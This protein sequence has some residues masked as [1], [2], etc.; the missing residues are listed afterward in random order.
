[1]PPI[2]ATIKSEN[3]S[4]DSTVSLAYQQQHSNNSSSSS[5]YNNNNINA[6]INGFEPYYSTKSGKQNSIANNTKSPQ[7][8]TQLPEPSRWGTEQI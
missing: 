1:M 7:T 3:I 4:S 5:S 8:T 2:S 6:K